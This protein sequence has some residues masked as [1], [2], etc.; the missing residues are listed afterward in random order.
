[1]TSLSC[2]FKLF[3]AGIAMSVSA[4]AAQASPPPVAAAPPQQNAADPF[5]HL[6]DDDDTCASMKAVK[7]GMLDRDWQIAA[8]GMMIPSGEKNPDGTGFILAMRNQT[9][10]R[11]LISED[12]DKLC[13]VDQGNKLKISTVPLRP[14]TQASLP[15]GFTSANSPVLSGANSETQDCAT[16]RDRLDAMAR[17]G[18]GEMNYRDGEGTVFKGVSMNGDKMRITADLTSATPHRWHWYK[19]PSDRQDIMCLRG[20][21]IG[22][23]PSAALKKRMIVNGQDVSPQQP[24]QPA[25]PLAPKH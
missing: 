4:L 6:A 21:G 8:T 1:M 17:S 10:W 19:I 9:D 18:R 2:R 25:P 7:A 23:T 16:V 24:P 5:L 12:G 11:I 20:G 22:Y 15:L 3:A 14:Y 13:L